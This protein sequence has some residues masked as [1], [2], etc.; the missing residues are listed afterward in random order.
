MKDR[1]SL[2]I[3]ASLTLAL[4]GCSKHSSATTAKQNDWDL[5]VVEVSDGVQIQRDLGRGRVCTIMPA[6]QKDGS[7]L[8]SLKLTQDGRLLTS[9]RIQTGTDRRAVMTIGDISIDVTPHF[10]PLA[11]DKKTVLPGRHM[12]ESQ[13]AEIAGRELS[14][15]QKFSCQF[16]DGVW[17]ILEFQ[18]GTWISSTTTN[19]D[20]QIVVHSTHPAQ[21]VLRVSDADGKIERIKTP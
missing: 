19:A 21:L 6:F 7:V 17:D 5:G 14:G 12:S 18:T 4:A 15:I 11:D 1:T 9:P 16:T 2:I 20:C 3:L 13:V 10:R 8:M